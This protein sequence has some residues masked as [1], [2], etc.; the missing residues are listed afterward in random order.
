MY[1]I[2]LTTRPNQTFN[3]T[4]P[5]DGDNR[6]LSFQLRYNA[7]AKYWN[8]TVID[9][10]TKKTLID[11]LALMVGEYPAANLLEQFSYMGLGSA[12]IVREGEIPTYENPDDKTLGTEYYL[13]WGDTIG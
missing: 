1:V 12:T 11:A 8:L 3:C 4:I 9:A 7:V 5:I 13:V 6:P 10:L 2:P